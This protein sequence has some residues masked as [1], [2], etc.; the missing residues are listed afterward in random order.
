MAEVPY[1]L[2]MAFRSGLG[3]WSVVIL[4]AGSLAGGNLGS[5]INIQHA[6]RSSPARG[7]EGGADV[8]AAL[9]TSGNMGSRGIVSGVGAALLVSTPTAR[10]LGILP[11]W[12]IVPWKVLGD[13]YGQ[14]GKDPRQVTR[15]RLA[16]APLDPGGDVM[17]AAHLDGAAFGV[18]FGVFFA[19]CKLRMGWRL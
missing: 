2:N 15:K 5:A 3:P 8:D 4:A 14:F 12:A 11:L 13:I 10:I 7:G 1:L 6:I 16:G 18:F 19:L 9:V 17:Y